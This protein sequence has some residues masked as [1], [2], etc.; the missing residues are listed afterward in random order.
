VDEDVAVAV[1]GF[2]GGV[3]KGIIDGV[4]VAQ[5][6]ASGAGAKLVATKDETRHSVD[7]DIGIKPFGA[8]STIHFQVPVH[9]PTQNAE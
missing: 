1:A 9:F 2:V 6:H 8:E 7:F 4:A 5:A 3:L